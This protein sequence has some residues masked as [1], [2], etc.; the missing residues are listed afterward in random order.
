MPKLPYHPRM[1]AFRPEALTWTGLLSKWMEFAQASLALPDDAEGRRWR[2]SV[3]PIINLQAVTFALGDLAKLDPADRPHARDKAAVLIRENAAALE[4]TWRGESM[5]A[6]AGEIIDDARAALANAIY[7]GAV[8]LIRPGDEPMVMPDVQPDLSA[9]GTLALMQPG[10][11]V[12]P[13]EPVAWR[14]DRP[15]DDLREA[16]P[17]CVEEPREPPRQVYRRFDEAGRIVRDEIVRITDDMPDG[18]P[19]LVPLLEEGR[20]IGEFTVDA[21]EWEDHQR[22]AMSGERI[23]VI[24]LSEESSTVRRDSS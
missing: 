5:P 21:T 10:T 15:G 19:L 6:L 7:I 8:E 14:V 4:E 9:G 18:L 22:A 12:M 2:A 11:I 17:D 23:E 1:T 16:L 3:T 13:N 20:V 24:D